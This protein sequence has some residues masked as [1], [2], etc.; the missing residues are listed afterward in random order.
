MARKPRVHF[1][2]ALYHVIARGNRGQDIFRDDQD[3]YLY[4]KYIRE[5]KERFHFYLHAYVLMV[6]HLHLLIEVGDVPLSRIMQVLQ[7]RYTRRYNLKYDLEGHLFQ[8]RYKAILCDK[9]SYLMQL[10]A[11]IHLNPVR[12]GIVKDPSEYPW[13]SYRS[14]ITRDRVSL[15]DRDF[16][17]SLF[18]GKKTSAQ[19]AYE[20]FVKDHLQEGH[21]E[22][23]YRTVDQRFLG[24]HEYVR[25]ARGVLEERGAKRHKIGLEYLASAASEVLALDRPVLYSATRNRKG[26]LGR[27]VVGYIGRRLCGYENKA[28]AAHFNMDPSA[29]SHGIKKVEQRIREDGSFAKRIKKLEEKFHSE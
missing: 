20:L 26:A 15:A 16:V 17:L 21:R 2:G 14:Y 22:D 23:L 9:D 28:V 8:G 1:P 19:R 12:A 18:A 25:S 7:F 13:S 11:Y 6:N 27:A 4:L 29:L 10:S 5:Y 3:H 24:D